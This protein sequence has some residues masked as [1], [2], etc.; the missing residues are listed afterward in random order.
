MEL[1]NL[2]LRHLSVRSS[3]FNGGYKIS[4]QTSKQNETPQ[5]FPTDDRL[6][7]VNKLL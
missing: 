2:A 6:S 4:K 7:G 5:Y 1:V 3:E